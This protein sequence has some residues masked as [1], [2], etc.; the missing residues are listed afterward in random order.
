MCE[1]QPSITIDAFKLCAL[2][3]VCA[4]TH[5]NILITSSRKIQKHALSSEISASCSLMS[6]FP[7]TISLFK[8]TEQTLKAL[9]FRFV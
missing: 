5:F 1:P 4:P 7:R 9:S 3:A 6:T 8:E 2:Y